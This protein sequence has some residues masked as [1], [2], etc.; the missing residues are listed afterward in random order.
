M[1]YPASQRFKMNFVVGLTTW[2][3]WKASDMCRGYD[4]LFSNDGS[5]M[6]CGIG[7]GVFSN[8]HSVDESHGFPRYASVF[9]ALIQVVLKVC[10]RL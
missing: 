3:E 5:R 6:V 9:Q 4:K 1:D 10:Q 7:T 8:T 2:V